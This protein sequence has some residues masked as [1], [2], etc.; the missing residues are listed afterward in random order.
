[1]DTKKTL[2]EQYPYVNPAYDIAIKSYDWC[3]HRSDSI[4]NTID[5]LLTWISSVTLAVITFAYTQK[6]TTNFESKWFK[7]SIILFF[8][9][10]LSGIVTKLMGSLKLLHPKI[11]HE[12][13]FSLSEFEFKSDILIRAGE[14]FSHNQ[15]L[16]NWKGWI[17]II[18]ILCFISETITLLMWMIS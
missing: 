16:V 5:K 4:D 7:V 2:E 8:G 12:N 15:F 18:M 9:S 10:I 17:S 11:I 14:A 13:F 1:M 3:I 6:I